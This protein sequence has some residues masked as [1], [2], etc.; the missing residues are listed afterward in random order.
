M[1][2]AAAGW[3]FQDS[4]DWTFATDDSPD[5]VVLVPL[6]DGNIPPGA[7]AAEIAAA[8]TATRESMAK[9]EQA[10][11]QST[12]F[13]QRPREWLSGG[14]LMSAYTSLHA[15]EA[16]RVNLL[17]SDQLAAMLPVIVEKATKYLSAGDPR[18]LALQ[19]LPDP[20]AP[21]HQ[22]LARVQKR[23]VE[24]VTALHGAAPGQAPQPAGP[25]QPGA[26][27]PAAA[28][29]PDLVALTPMLGRDQRIA[30]MALNEANRA[31]DQQ[32]AQVRRFRGVMLSIFAGLAL[33]VALLA[34]L[35]ATRSGYFPLCLKQQTSG[36][37]HAT[38]VCPTGGS[39]ADPADL[40]FTMAI[41]AI[42]AILAVA[43]NLSG[44]APTGVRYSLSVAKG[45]VKIP[46]G[47]ITAMLGIIIL[48]TQSNIGVLATHAGLISTAAV[49]GY[50][51]QVF[52]KFIDKRAD[53]LMSQA[54]GNT[55]S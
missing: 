17:S 12:K 14:L 10:L 23:L 32:Q 6:A 30:A 28:P 7:S 55:S 51:Q 25:A 33:L 48:S 47:A 13:R 18:L 38:V 20:T 21:T 3:K 40:A 2:L 43:T 1:S 29:P 8:V 52:T 27:P 50:S 11:R 31:E 39:K 26:Q 42:G 35:G 24:T 37:K 45:L 53:T 5:P 46:F 4:P 22:V 34:I 36:P 16:N 9:T 15:A 54:G 41:G 44:L 19:G 49:F